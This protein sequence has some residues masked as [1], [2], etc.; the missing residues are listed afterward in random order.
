[1]DIGTAKVTREEM[2]G[3]PHYMLDIIDPD[4][5]FSVAEFKEQAIEII[6]DILKRKKIP[7]LVGGTML[8]LD[9][10]TKNLQFPKAPPNKE[11][12]AKLEKLNKEELLEK[13]KKLDPEMFELIDQ[14]N[15]RK[16][17]RALEYCL[18]TGEK[19]S[20]A[21]K[22]GPELFE[23]ILIGINMPRET[24]YQR[25][26]MRA[27]EQIKAGLIEESKNLAKK[28]HFDLPSMSGIGYKQIGMYIR[29]E[30]SLEEAIRL[31][32]RDTRRYAVRQL[33]W[34]R[35]DRRIKWF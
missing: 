34:W 27:D 23:S 28:Y 21:Q 8:Y 15:A 18:T 4:E 13:L 19:F 31:Q 17:V 1:M 11:I 7:F 20:D 9:A 5:E 29:N 16:V 26:N 6:E 2:Q 30:V 3:V 32:K 35:R 10:I 33:T 22:S 25:I 24:L 12:R 14:S